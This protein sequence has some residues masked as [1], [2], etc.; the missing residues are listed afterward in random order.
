VIRLAA[1][2]QHE[3]FGV[4]KHVVLIRAIARKNNRKSLFQACVVGSRRRKA[5]WMV[6]SDQSDMTKVGVF[7]TDVAV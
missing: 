1:G 3:E 4:E 5:A 7:V 6:A 2:D